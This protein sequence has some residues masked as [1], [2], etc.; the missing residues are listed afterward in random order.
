MF[1]GL[2]S[3]IEDE[4][5]RL[6]STVSQYGENI[7]NQVRSTASEAGSDISGRA[8]KFIDSAQQLDKEGRASS[9]NAAPTE[10]FL[11]QIGNKPLRRLSNASLE[12]GNESLLNAQVVPNNIR[13]SDSP[14]NDIS[15]D[16]ESN[17]A[18]NADFD[19]LDEMP[20]DKLNAIFQRF[21]ARAVNYRQKYKELSSI[22]REIENENEKYKNLLSAT[23]EKAAQRIAKLKTDRSELQEKLKAIGN[24]EK[25]DEQS[26]KIK[27]LQDLLIKCK[28]EITSNRGRITSLNDENE[29][30]KKENSSLSSEN[31]SNVQR[32]TAEWKGRFDR[33]EEEWNRRISEC[34]EKATIAIATSKAEMHSALQQKDQELENWISKFHTLE[35]KDAEENTQLKEKLSSLEEAILTLEQ[36]KADMVQKLSQAKQEGVKLV[37]ESEER[38]YNDALAVELKKRD[39]E[40]G[41]RLK[42]MEDQM[43]LSVEENDMQRK[44]SHADHERIIST[45]KERIIELEKNNASVLLKLHEHEEELQAKTEE[46]CRLAKTETN[47]TSNQQQQKIFDDKLAEEKKK[48]VAEYEEKISLIEKENL[49]NKELTISEL[50]IEHNKKLNELNEK[51]DNERVELQTKLEEVETKFLKSK[52]EEEK[53]ETI[54]KSLEGQLSEARMTIEKLEMDIAQIRQENELKDKDETRYKDLLATQQRKSD[55]EWNVRVKELEEQLNLS[56]QENDLLQKQIADDERITNDLKERIESLEKNNGSLQKLIEQKKEETT[57]YSEE[58][59]KIF[60]EKLEEERKKIIDEYTEKIALIEKESLKTRDDALIEQRKIFEV[61]LATEKKQIVDEYSERISTLEAKELSVQQKIF[62]EKLS[63]ERKRLINEYSE[64]ISLLEKEANESKQHA[65]EEQQ[66]IFDERFAEERKNIIDEYSGRIASIEKEDIEVKERLISEIRIEND[67]KLKELTEKHEK[68]CDGLQNKVL[69]IESENLKYKEA[70]SAAQITIKSLEEQLYESQK[71]IGKF[72]ADIVQLCQENAS[73]LTEKE[74][75]VAKRIEEIKKEFMEK[76]ATDDQNSNK[77]IISLKEELEEY[78]NKFEVLQV[79]SKQN[80]LNYNEAIENLN[81]LKITLKESD[82]KSENLAAQLLEEKSKSSDSQSKHDTQISEMKEALSS[83]EQLKSQLQLE[84][85]NAKLELKKQQQN[86][87]LLNDKTS[88]FEETNK[89]F[90]A[91]KSAK[92]NEIENLKKKLIEAEEA[93]LKEVT[94]IKKESEKAKQKAI[95]DMKSE[96]KHLYDSINEKDCELASTHADISKLREELDKLRLELDKHINSESGQQQQKQRSKGSYDDD[97]VVDL[98]E[99]VDLKRRFIEQEEELI[100]LKSMTQNGVKK[101]PPNTRRDSNR[102]FQVGGSDLLNFAEPTEAEYLRNVLYRYMI[103]REYL[104]RE[105][106]T[107][108]KVICTVCKFPPEQRNLVLRR[109]EARCQRWLPGSIH[110][111]NLHQSQVNQRNRLNSLNNWNISSSALLQTNN[112]DRPLSNINALPYS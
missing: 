109:E 19:Q 81:Q 75:E 44:T 64:K 82:Q 16:T 99:Y 17:A 70:E 46:L 106:V 73:K 78:K 50:Q 92:L 39:E 7:A 28:D 23:Q 85:K 47:D 54:I 89:K 3:K 105:S 103:E 79:T 24:G 31:S 90:S 72:E 110:A 32:V 52:E 104:G 2:R 40:W 76:K 65:L 18:E 37:K 30:L 41:D 98:D 63:N 59:Q 20:R 27:K 68:E 91:F 6:K 74:N 48:I 51:Y 13:L 83:C 66:K 112:S 25:V 49:R 88:E 58:Q 4:A 100:R 102:S 97:G 57:E 93:R 26:E 61:Q 84:L 35:K 77:E 38:R 62:E 67:K 94:E 56:V 14:L 42:E 9:S 45:L 87:K 69:K 5:N 29:H 95:A 71:T 101:D 108:A 60:E 11:D 21:Q 8:R 22:Y 86:E 10:D 111:L 80:E 53:A 33:Q 55:E 36:E 96:I 12:S 34:E 107:L 1:K 43:Q 15:S